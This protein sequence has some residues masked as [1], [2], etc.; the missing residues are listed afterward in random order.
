MIVGWRRG[1]MLKGHCLCG[2]VRVEVD[3]TGTPPTVCHCGMC[4]RW[5]GALGAY[6]SA[7]L[8]TW[9]VQGSEHVR[10]FGSS[11]NAERGFCDVCGS[12]LFWRRKGSASLDPAL[13]LFDRPTGL[14]LGAHIWVAHKGGY[15]RIGDGVPCYAESM[16]EVAI[17]EPDLPS[18]PDAPTHRGRCLCGVVSFRVNGAMRPIVTCHCGMCRRWHGHFAAYTSA[19][20][21]DIELSG[22]AE[23][24]WF[25]SSDKAKRGFCRRCGSSLFWAPAGGERWSIAAGSLHEP[26]GL[27]TVRHIFTADKGDSYRIADG[28]RESP[29]SMAMD[30]VIG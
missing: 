21:A 25:L 14:S 26:T 15:Y 17:A 16:G 6:T 20:C 8:G 22:L 7:P 29:G 13:G 18:E 24:R 2:R 1:T 28:V 9:R 11:P 27:R 19:K 12:K 5:H 10:W 30:P 23:V 4:R 3:G